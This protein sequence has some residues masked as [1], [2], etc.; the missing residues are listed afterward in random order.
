[1]GFITFRESLLN[2]KKEFQVSLTCFLINNAIHV[3]SQKYSSGVPYFIVKTD[4][5]L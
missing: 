5:D 3:Q 2:Y 1:M 4:D